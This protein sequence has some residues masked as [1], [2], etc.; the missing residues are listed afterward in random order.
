MAAGIMSPRRSWSCFKIL[1]KLA[2]L[3]KRFAQIWVLVDTRYQGCLVVFGN[4]VH[5][6]R[7]VRDG[8]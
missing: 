3:K 5:A 2:E 6:L 1:L 4:L 7:Q 8:V